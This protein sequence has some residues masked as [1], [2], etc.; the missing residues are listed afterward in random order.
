[1]TISGIDSF[2]AGTVGLP[3]DGTFDIWILI[4]TVPVI[5]ECLKS[6]M[7]NLALEL[8]KTLIRKPPTRNPL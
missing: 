4:L 5:R 7:V 6:V 8:S 3:A 1:M 2:D